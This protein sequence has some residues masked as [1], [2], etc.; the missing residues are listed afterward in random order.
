MA[1]ISETPVVTEGKK[2]TSKDL[3]ML[4]SGEYQPPE[5]IKK[6]L[7]VSGLQTQQE[8]ANF[9]KDMNMQFAQGAAHGA[10]EEAIAAMKTGSIS[11]PEYIAERSK[12]RSQL[13]AV[14]KERPITSAIA[15]G[16]GG[17]VTTAAVPFMSATRGARAG[18]EI[19]S[20]ALS[21]AGEAP[22]MKDIPKSALTSAAIQT[23]LE[24]AGRLVKELA[25]DDPT[26]ILTRSIGVSTK[27]MRAP[28]GRTAADAVE[29]LRKVGFF[30]SGEKF[31]D[32]SLSKF[33]K[34]TKSLDS[35]LKPQ[36]LETLNETAQ[37]A[38]NVL[39]TKNNQL[40]RGKTIRP[41]DLI[42]ELNLGVADMTYDPTG[43][44]VE[45][46]QA[47]ADEV[48]NVI[49][50]DLVAKG[51]YT[52]NGPI[53]AT[54]IEEAKKALDAHIGSPAFKKNAEDL[55]INPEAM[56]LFRKRL[57]SVVDSVAGPTYK[58]NNDLMSDLITVR[59][60]IQNT[61]NRS[62]VEAGGRLLDT[63]SP[64]QKVMSVISPTPVD[65]ARSQTSAAIEQP[66]GEAIGQLG[67]RTLREAFTGKRTPQGQ[68]ED[69]VTRKGYDFSKVR[70]AFPQA[71][72][73]MAIAKMKLPRTTKG[74]LEN[75]EAVI[76]KLMVNGVPDQMIETITQALNEDPDAIESVGSMIAMQFPTLFEKSKYKMFDGKLL[77]PNERAKA[78]DD[79]SKRD[80]LNSV[81]KAKIINELNK[82]GKWLGE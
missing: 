48:K 64:Y 38:I 62:Y 31:V 63:R 73:P 26:K 10:G 18:K 21:G 78:A 49:L 68:V 61:E 45:A 82:T 20:A 53:R 35:F 79:T 52:P 71:I 47:L 13:A 4:A 16:L 39:K 67:K 28:E 11:S 5:G 56:M 55:G 42:S 80:D 15:Q 29:R 32:P 77:D 25:F 23:G 17:M 66:G 19:L 74:L 1:G 50:N 7:V 75:K 69:F 54:A 24:G 44:N 33:V 8:I 51:H 3:D 59:N 46:R 30:D 41:K 76:T 27:D 43:Y 65:I 14:E 9:V 70:K 36:N 57:D 72:D 37:Q 81:Q 22:E 6:P 60:I 12:L 58:N 34:N 2:L 40:I